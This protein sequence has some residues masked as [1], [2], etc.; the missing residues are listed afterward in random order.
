MGENEHEDAVES[1]GMPGLD[2][3]EDPPPF[4]QIVSSA[5]HAFGRGDG[6]YA[7]TEVL[8][9]LGKDGSVWEYCVSDPD[10]AGARDGWERL[11]H[12]AYRDGEEPKGPRKTR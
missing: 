8:Y 9:G 6:E 2:E 3:E 4:I 11:P 12:V 1:E 5:A 7:G 10:R